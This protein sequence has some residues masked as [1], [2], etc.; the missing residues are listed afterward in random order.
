[1]L[2]GTKDGFAQDLNKI[3]P[4][5]GRTNGTSGIFKDKYLQY[6]DVQ[7]T[8]KNIFVYSFIRAI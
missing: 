1:M 5:S 2:A 3:M 7:S 6:Y 8:K 4:L